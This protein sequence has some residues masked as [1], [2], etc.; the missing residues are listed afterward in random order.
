MES[1]VVTD[2]SRRSRPTTLVKTFSADFKQI[3]FEIVFV[4]RKLA[5]Y[6][7]VVFCSVFLSNPCGF[8][9]HI[10]YYDPLVLQPKGK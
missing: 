7:M 10:L 5:K 1:I 2:N 9:R 8:I 4:F 6:K 3:A